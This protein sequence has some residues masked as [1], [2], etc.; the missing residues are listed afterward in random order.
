MR[1]AAPMLLAALLASACGSRTGLF[2]PE[3][4]NDCAFPDAAS[5][6]SS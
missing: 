3:A 6:S 4:K 5:C 2:A 1:I